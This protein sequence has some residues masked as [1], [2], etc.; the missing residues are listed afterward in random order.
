MS[1]VAGYYWMDMIV[2]SMVKNLNVVKDKKNKGE[3]REGKGRKREKI[4]RKYGE[5]G[6]G[7]KK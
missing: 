2:I 3:N 1:P 7:D 4:V 6:Q 5:D